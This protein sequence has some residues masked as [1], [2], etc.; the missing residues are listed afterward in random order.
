MNNEKNIIE[1]NTNNNNNNNLIKL[2]PFNGRSRYLIDKFYI[3]GYNYFTLHKLLIDNIPKSIEQDNEKEKEAKALHQ[4]NLEE[5]PDILNE[6][7]SDFNKVGLPNETILNMIYPKKLNFYYNCEDLSQY[8]NKTTYTANKNMNSTK[9]FSK[10]DFKKEMNS[11]NFP[12]SYKVVFSSNPQS[13][14][15]SKK[16]IN[17]FAYIFYKK[18]VEI[19]LLYTIYFLYYK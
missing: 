7:T 18:F 15:N 4:F 11:Q 8:M 1:E 10:I 5:E 14:N 3:I 6:I 16:S 19:Y 17:G 13:E 2:Y 12:K 9:N